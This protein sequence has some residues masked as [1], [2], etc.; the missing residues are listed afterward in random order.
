MQAADT[1]GEILRAL[2]GLSKPLLVKVAPD[3]ADDDLEAMLEVMVG[4]V[5]GVIATNT[6]V[7]RPD[8]LEIDEAGGLSG[9]PLRDRATEVVR[10]IYRRTGGK[11]PIVG[12]GGVAT[13]QDV[14]DKMMAGA[15]LVQLYTGFIYEG[16]LVVRSINRGLLRCLE[17]K[18]LS[19]VM[20]LTGREA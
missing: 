19:S 8:G 12:V 1:L 13:A 2:S 7:A 15:T 10:F 16:P 5:A 6:T 3:L 11:L 9:R 18:G 20:Q 17:E 4:R 14:I